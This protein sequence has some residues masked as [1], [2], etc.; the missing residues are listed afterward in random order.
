MIELRIPSSTIH[1]TREAALDRKTAFAPSESI[2]SFIE[3]TLTRALGTRIRALSVSHDAQFSSPVD[4]LSTT[5]FEMTCIRLDLIYNPREVTRLVDHGPAAEDEAGCRQFQDFWG[6]KSELRRF[7]DGRITESVVWEAPTAFARYSIPNQIISHILKTKFDISTDCVKCM[8]TFDSLLAESSVAIKAI[9]QSDPELKGWTGMLGAFNQLTAILRDF[10]DLPLTI[11]AITPSSPQLRQTSP[12]MP[13][14]RKTRQFFTSPTTTQCVSPAE[15]TVT[16]ESSSKWPENLEAVQKVKAAFLVQFADMIHLKMADSQC[17]LIL[18]PTAPAFADHAALDILLASGYAFR[19]FIH[20]EKEKQLLA[21]M[22][23]DSSTPLG[24]AASKALSNHQQRFIAKPRHHTAISTLTHL[25]PS[26]PFTVRLLLRWLNAHLLSPHIEEEAVELLCASIYLEANPPSSPLAGFIECLTKLGSWQWSQDPLLVPLYTAT[27]QEAGA[28][29]ERKVQ[30]PV[31]KA[32]TCKKSFH[33]RKEAG[34]DKGG[35]CIATEEDIIGK[36]FAFEKPP[37]M[38]AN[39]VQ[40]LA[41]AALFALQQSLTE[42]FEYQ[43]SVS[44]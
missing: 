31:E 15:F 29:Y 2:L 10:D 39:R 12:F 43:V 37:K 30:F 23:F 5:V 27:R 8:P 41:I 17:S 13:G 25:Y 42:T 35:W 7:N 16:F 11:K 33:A 4:S 44:E 18:D 36:D 38:I 34:L 3:N 14:P 20:Y 9:Y 19:M 24:Q 22:A 28:N 40:Q 1:Q 32:L 21:D 26:F 6:E